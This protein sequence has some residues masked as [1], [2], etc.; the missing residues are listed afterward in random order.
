MQ[1][2]QAHS[3]TRDQRVA[4]Q[5]HRGRSPTSLSTPGVNHVQKNLTSITRAV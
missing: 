1:V 4:R 3:T 2:R 5:N